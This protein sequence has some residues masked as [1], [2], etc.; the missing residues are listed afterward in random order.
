MVC[1]TC[2][3]VRSARSTL[4]GCEEEGQGMVEWSRCCKPWEGPAVHSGAASLGRG[5]QSTQVRQA[6]GGACSPLRCGAGC[7]REIGPSAHTPQQGARKMVKVLPQGAACNPPWEGAA[8][9]P[10]WEVGQLEEIERL[11]HAYTQT[12]Q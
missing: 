9:N 8:C 5:L 1:S 2:F 10:P 4:A 12:Q 6:M 3:T 11:V 7:D